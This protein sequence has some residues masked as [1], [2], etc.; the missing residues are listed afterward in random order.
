MLNGF[1]NVTITKDL[2]SDIVNSLKDLAKKTVCVGIPDATEHE[3]SKISNA[4][5]LYLNTNGV[6]DVS[7][8][9]EM[10][11]NL[12]D[13][14][15][16][17]KAHE[18]YV[19]EHGSPLWRIPPR[20]VLEPALDNSKEQIA[21]LMKDTVNI[22]LDGGNVTPALNVVG[23]QGQNIARDWFTNPDNNWAPN[24]DSTING[25][26]SHW[27]KFFKGKGSDKPLID[28]GEMRKSITY[29][30]KDGDI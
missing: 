13:G 5:I 10:Q 23:M 15:T 12:N 22:A 1:T 17:S 19:H 25:W 3:D 14:M 16:Y 18:L 24:A 28:T 6:R 7:M 4:Q 27:G 8:R 30:V 26:K 20:P 29:V 2:T 9:N 11:H 21:E